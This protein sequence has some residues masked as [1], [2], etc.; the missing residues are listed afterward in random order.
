MALYIKRPKNYDRATSH[1]YAPKQEKK[2]AEEL[3]G[4]TTPRSGGG[5]LKGDIH[6]E[7]EHGNYQID[8][9]CT[10]KKSYSLKLKDWQK[11]KQQ[12][13]QLGQ[14][15]ILQLE[16]ISEVESKSGSSI[17]KIA[18]MDYDLFKYY[19]ELETKYYELLQRK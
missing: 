17:E 12:A 6:T 10:Q 4:R 16:Y 7:L 2:V 19:K 3:K 9:K 13:R 15:F 8:C 1:K 5:D 14:H 18:M 11:Y